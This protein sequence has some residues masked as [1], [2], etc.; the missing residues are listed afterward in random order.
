MNC[1]FDRIFFEKFFFF[2]SIFYFHFRKN[3]IEKNDEI[4]SDKEDSDEGDST[5]VENDSKTN[6]TTDSKIIVKPAKREILIDFQQQRKQL[7]KKYLI[8]G[9]SLSII[10]LLVGIALLVLL[11][12]NS[13]PLYALAWVCGVPVFCILISVFIF[14]MCIPSTNQISNSLDKWEKSRKIIP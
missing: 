3:R 9:I 11:I 12:V 7:K 4:E 10:G 13:Q 1:F 5:D 8:I 6:Q 2:K 14:F